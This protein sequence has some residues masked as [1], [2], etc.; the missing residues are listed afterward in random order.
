MKSIFKNGALLTTRKYINDY[1]VEHDG[2]IVNCVGID[3]DFPGYICYPYALIH[4]L[5]I[6]NFNEIP[7]LKEI[8]DYPIQSTIALKDFQQE[9]MSKLSEEPYGIFVSAPGTGKTVCALWLIAHLNLRALVLVNSVFL[10]DQ[11]REEREKFLNYSPGVIGDGSFSIKDI[12]IATFQSARKKERLEQI[13]DYFSFVVVDECHRVPADTFKFVLSNVCAYWKLGITGTYRRKDGLEFVANFMLG[14]KILVNEYDDTMKPEIIIVKTGIKLPL[15]DSYVECLN[16]MGEDKE[17]LGILKNC[18]E[19]CKD[20]H[21]L[22][23]SFR[24]NTVE[25][26]KEMFPKAIFVTGSTDRK[27]RQNLNER[28]LTSNLIISTTLQEGVNIPNLDTL[29]LIHPNNNL[30]MLKQRIARIV[31]TVDNKKVPLILDYWYQQ[32]KTSGFSVYNQQMQRL[33]FYEQQ[34]YKTYVIQPKDC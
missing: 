33:A 10:L 11:W 31:R 15:S 25:V 1:A 30:P 18:I 9:H 29:H 21:Q 16:E 4:R 22:I 19:R 14:D 5:G 23:L 34:G 32:G 26:L 8:E 27:G 7:E 20:R 24:L 2:K 12:T 3:N 28:V 6:N 17:I 13:K